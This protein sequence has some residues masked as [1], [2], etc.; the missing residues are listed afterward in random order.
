MTYIILHDIHFHRGKDWETIHWLETIG[1]YAKT[2][3]HP[4]SPLTVCYSAT[5]WF[6][7]AFTENVLESLAFEYI[8]KRDADESDDSEIEKYW[9]NELG[10]PNVQW[11]CLEGGTEELVHRLKAK[12]PAD[13]IFLKHRVKKMSLESGARIDSRRMRV[14]LNKGKDDDEVRNYSAVINSTT[15]AAL[16]KMDLTSLDLPYGMK[17]AIR[18]LRYDSSTKVGIKFKKPW[19]ITENKIENGGLGKTDMPLRIWYDFFSLTSSSSP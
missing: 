18:S 9:R 11:W 6:D 10:I 7:Q 14:V 1:R 19:W 16:Q 15:L 4:K 3:L 2:P 17:A 13:K 8:N 12:L 5:G